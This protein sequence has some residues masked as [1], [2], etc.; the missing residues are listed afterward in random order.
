M[1]NSFPWA[2]RALGEPRSGCESL[3]NSGG[4]KL[5]RT[6]R[7]NLAISKS[8]LNSERTTSFITTFGQVYMLKKCANP[9]CST[10][11][12]YLR[13]GKIFMMEQPQKPQPTGKTGGDG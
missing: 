8:A 1:F 3:A 13:E 6:S 7:L 10:P 5:H 11:L 4:Q 2:L 9:S 12:V